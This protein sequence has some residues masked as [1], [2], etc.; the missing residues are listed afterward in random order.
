MTFL[1]IAHRGAS[2]EAPENTLAA[3]DLALEQ[4]AKA[5][6]LD[7]RLSADGVP[8][9]I[10]DATVERT[11]DGHGPVAGHTLAQ[12]KALDAGS[13]FG[14]RFA[15]ERVPALEEVL[16]RY[17]G[18]ARL[19]IEL[20][21]EEVELPAGV[22][23]LVRQ[24]KAEH[25][26]IL[27]SFIKAQLE[28]ARPLLPEVPLAWL[29]RRFNNEVIQE[30]AEAGFQ[31]CCPPAALVTAE[32]VREAKARGLTVVAWGVRSVE[33]LGR[34]VGCGAVAATVDWPDRARKNI[35][36][37]FAGPARPSTRSG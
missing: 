5:L 19:Q 22:A 33:E 30:A 36:R 16:V 2:A 23:A 20:K 15:G 11:T 24:H 34:L 26:I 17:R 8:V 12:L 10:H 18:K 3:F 29:V 31:S 1:L 32:L 6:E 25:D 13:W 27:S 35:E 21:S 14:P 37:K 7:V 28:R 4:G 9:A